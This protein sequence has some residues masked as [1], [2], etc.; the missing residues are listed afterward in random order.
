MANRQKIKSKEQKEK[1]RVRSQGNIDARRKLHCDENKNDKQAQKIMK[2][3][4][5]RRWTK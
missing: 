4:S 5:Y 2:D 3:H 1:Q